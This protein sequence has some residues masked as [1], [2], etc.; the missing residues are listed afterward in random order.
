MAKFYQHFNTTNEKTLGK[1]VKLKYIDDIS[2]DDL[3]LYHF[4]DGTYCSEDCIGDVEVEDPI[5]KKCF[6]VEVLDPGRKW[7]IQRQIFEPE[8]PEPTVGA[9]GNVYEP[10]EY[11]V[12][13]K[14]GESIRSAGSVLIQAF[15]P[16]LP[17][18]W[19]VEDADN[20]KLSLHPELENVDKPAP[21][22]SN[23][24]Q[25]PIQQNLKEAFNKPQIEQQPQYQQPAQPVIHNQCQPTVTQHVN[26]LDMVIDF[27]TI[28][29]NVKSFKILKD[30]QIIT[31][32]KE[33][34]AERLL[35]D[36]SHAKPALSGQNIIDTEN[37][38]IKSM[39]DMSKKKICK[40]SLNVQLELP[41]KE[42][43]ET[44]S[45]AYDNVYAH[46]FV[47]SLTARIPQDS[48][49]ESLAIGLEK[50][51]AGDLCSALKSEEIPEEK[52]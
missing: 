15:A 7:D 32:D 28:S 44:I 30:D 51:Y 9:D 25:Q 3:N 14:T 43:Y 21:A 5:T 52:Y 17:R 12:N 48:L 26:T 46:E 22:Y 23:S 29:P 40:I 31:L 37:V 10:V 50:Y 27:N 1:V 49:L 18:R 42:V 4:D 24:P 45:K 20:Y 2:D 19:Q 34:V 39:I 11:N 35:N 8:I 16:Q 33:E 41:P 47:K 38:L 6:M 13:V 36:N